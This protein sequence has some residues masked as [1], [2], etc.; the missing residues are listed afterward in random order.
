MRGWGW[1][2]VG[3]AFALPVFG[4]SLLVFAAIEAIRL[5]VPGGRNGVAAA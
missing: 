2:A 4:W 5:V 1:V 3:L